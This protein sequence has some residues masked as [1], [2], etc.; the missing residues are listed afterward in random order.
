MNKYLRYF[1]I[2]FS[3]SILS[4][5]VWLSSA[6]FATTKQHHHLTSLEKIQKNRILHVVL[7][8]GKKGLEYTLIKKFADY[9]DVDLDITFV[10]TREEALSLYRNSNIDII[11]A[12]IEKTEER[13][14]LYDFGP[15]YF[16]VQ[17]QMIC[18]RQ[19]PRGKKI[20]KDIGMLG[21]LNIMIREDSI[22]AETLQ[23]FID[24]GYDIDVEYTDKFSEKKLLALVNESTIN[25][26]IVNSDIYAKN[27]RHLRNTT[28][29][30]SLSEKKELAWIF[31][32][33]A[34][35]LKEKTFEWFASYSQTQEFQKI[36]T[37]FYKQSV[38]KRYVTYNHRSKIFCK[39]IK[40]RLCLYEHYFKKY[41][42]IYNLP[43]TLLASMA[44]QE[45]LWN[46]LATSFTGVRGMMMLTNRTARMLGVENRLNARES[47]FG[48]TKHIKYLI[49]AVPKEIVDEDKLR[50]ALAAYNVGMGHIY[51]ARKLA[52]E[53]SYNPNVWDDVKRVLPLLSKKEYYKDLKYGKARGSEPVHYVEAIYKYRSI[54]ENYLEE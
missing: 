2:F 13:S 48:G 49:Q 23:S 39:R 40:T 46:P 4:A 8:D 1:L 20:P 35:S 54:L 16:Q 10:P 11:A 30:F 52:K 45:S 17:E 9:L 19:I 5:V 53:L 25:C 41:G 18:S 34:P 44:Y 6:I 43:W 24:D 28:L 26:T 47:I 33:Q 15:S 50:F 38:K 42:E 31:A 22:H 12:N 14:K 29:A 21:G 3:L 51:D 7:L 36:R 32:H 37:A 27:H